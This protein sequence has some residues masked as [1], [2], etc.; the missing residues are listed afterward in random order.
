MR[1]RQR[2]SP[3]CVAGCANIGGLLIIGA[4]PVITLKEILHA[5]AGS[6]IPKMGKTTDA[7]MPHNSP[8]TILKERRNCHEYPSTMEEVTIKTYKSD[9][10]MIHNLTISYSIDG[11]NT[12]LSVDD[13]NYDNLPYNLAHMFSRAIEDTNANP[14]IV[15]Q[16]MEEH[17]EV[18]KL[19]SG[20]D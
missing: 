11:I 10:N 1:K 6:S 17:C 13:D 5:L 2:K 14:I 4:I 8:V 9:R 15:I 20:L 3:Y 16:E 7:T 19:Q 18:G 12:T